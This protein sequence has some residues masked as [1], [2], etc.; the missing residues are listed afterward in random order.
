M[1][2]RLLRHLLSKKTLTGPRIY[3]DREE[4]VAT[5]LTGR[6]EVRDELFECLPDGK[7]SPFKIE[8]RD[9]TAY[10][11]IAPIPHFCRALRSLGWGRQH[12]NAPPQRAPS[13]A[14]QRRSEDVNQ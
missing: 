13:R 9:A 12:V 6:V 2:F 4:G 11:V 7:G 10:G 5:F 3:L 14:P 1:R 8:G